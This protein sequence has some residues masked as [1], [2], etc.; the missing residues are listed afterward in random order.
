M[1]RRSWSRAS[2]GTP[3]AMRPCGGLAPAFGPSMR[4]TVDESVWRFCTRFCGCFLGGPQAPG[5]GCP[6][7]PEHPVRGEAGDRLRGSPQR[8]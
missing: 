5:L 2:D 8:W 7:S 3:A 6:V 1:P 4:H